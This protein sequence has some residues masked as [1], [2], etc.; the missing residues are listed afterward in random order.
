MIPQTSIYQ[1]QWNR[2]LFWYVFFVVFPAIVIVQNLS[3][4]FFV[5]LFFTVARREQPIQI[6]TTLQWV[7]IA[8][9]VSAI[10]SVAD[11]NVKKPDAFARAFVVLPNYLY[12]VLIILFF[13][14]HRSKL[15]LQ[16][17]YKA[18]FY[19]VLCSVCYY[20]FF[21]KI[22]R[23]FPFATFPQNSFAFLIICYAPIAVF[24]CQKRFGLL[25]G[26]VLGSLLT[27]AAFL[28]GS[29]AGSLLTFGGV[30]L[31]LWL[32]NFSLKW[33][34]PFA[35][36]GWFFGTTLIE[37]DLIKT[38]VKN[39]NPET[40]D[41]IYERETVLKTDRSYLVRVA[42]VEKG[43]E[44][45]KKHPLTGVG[46]NN[47]ANVEVKIPGDFEGALYVKNKDIFETK[48]AHNSYVGLLAEG[49]L[50]ALIPFLILL[51]SCILNFVFFSATMNKSYYPVFVGI[52]GMSVH[53]YF[54]TAIVNVFAWM[55]I[56]LGVACI[57][58]S[59]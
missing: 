39:L 16:I 11:V 53:L 46:L 13:V 37:L 4:F 57:Y 42:M 1:E 17:I 12:W 14:A 21:Q 8:F 49:G 29:R 22:L 15:N 28:S 52:I 58:K 2:Y 50:F 54:I 6:T 38:V 19:A 40:Y 3:F 55:L 44:L 26:V 25:W 31:V 18:I 45:Y 27:V 32:D 20:F 9:G 56:A 41:L 35:L 7:A 23:F 10:I 48:S 30:C 43:I 5:L 59:K 33:L 34:I 47:F 36:I 24:Y 51:F